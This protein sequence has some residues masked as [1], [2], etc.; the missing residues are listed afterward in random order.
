M[1]VLV[2]GRIPQEVLDSLQREHRVKVNDQDR[3]MTRRAILELIADQDGLIPMVTDSIDDALMARAPKLRIIANYGVG[4]NNIELA[5]ASARKILVTNTPGVLTDATAD[6][7]FAL[8]L[9]IAR[10]V[11]EGDRMTREGRFQFWA[12]MHFLGHEVTGSTLGIVGI[13]RIGR[14]VA[15]RAAGFDMKVLYHSRTRLDPAQEAALGIKYAAFD[16]LLEN[17]DFVS[18]HV[19]LTPETRHLIGSA[20]LRRMKASAFLI[21]TSRGPVVDESALVEAL[22]A[23]EIAGAGLDV[24][25]NEPALDPGLMDLNSV[26]LLPHSGSATRETRMKMAALA[27]ENLLTALRGQ[28]PPNCLN[29][30]DVHGS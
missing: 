18:L 25:E 6:I 27:A 7:T 8:I 29:W 1:K 30:E 4:Y 23:G 13:G 2:T 10:R 12:P 5:A 3:P 20:Q 26:V 16:Y 15:K 9:A 21:N 14:A 17:S 19:P 22:K 11:V 24:Y 28:R